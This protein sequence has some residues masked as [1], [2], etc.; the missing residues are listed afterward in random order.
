MTHAQAKA[1]EEKYNVYVD[2]EE[3]IYNHEGQDAIYGWMPLTD[4]MLEDIGKTLSWC[5]QCAS[6][7]NTRDREGNSFCSDYCRDYF[8]ING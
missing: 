5:L 1:I 6:A 2:A 4:E 8:H 7:Y 3:E